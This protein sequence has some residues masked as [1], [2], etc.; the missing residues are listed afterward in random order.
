MIRWTNTTTDPMGQFESLLTG[1]NAD[2]RA[3]AIELWSSERIRRANR[4]S[5]QSD[6]QHKQLMAGFCWSI[7]TL[8]LVFAALVVSPLL[9][10]PGD[11]VGSDEHAHISR[12]HAIGGIE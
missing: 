12:G 10:A 8:V 6:A 2:D 11:H 1:L 3:Q 7:V 5:R 4:A 9:D